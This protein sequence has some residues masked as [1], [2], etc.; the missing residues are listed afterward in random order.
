[1]QTISIWHQAFAAGDC[2]SFPPSCSLKPEL[3][4]ISSITVVCGGSLSA[5]CCSEK[6]RQNCNGGLRSKKHHSP[7]NMI[8]ERVHYP[9][10]VLSALPFLER[11]AS[12]Y[13]PFK[14]VLQLLK[15]TISLVLSQK[16]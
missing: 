15:I 13:H 16:Q 5:R 8:W 3:F 10:L 4:S 6:L 2:S 14:E 7:F 12:F 11:L 9:C 1:M